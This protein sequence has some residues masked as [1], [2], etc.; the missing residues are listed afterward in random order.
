MRQRCRRVRDFYAYFRQAEYP[1]G[2]VRSLVMTLP[3][4]RTRWWR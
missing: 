4:F 2:R 1:N 3:M